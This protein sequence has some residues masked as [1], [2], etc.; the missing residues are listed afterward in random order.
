MISFSGRKTLLQLLE[1]VG[2]ITEVGPIKWITSDE[3]LMI[4]RTYK[5]PSKLGG[6]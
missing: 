4:T 5:L 1:R 3:N 2:L 6:A